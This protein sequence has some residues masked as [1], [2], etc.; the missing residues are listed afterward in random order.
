MNDQK[1]F[2]LVKAVNRANFNAVHMFALDAVFN[3]N[4]GHGY[5]R[6]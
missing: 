6:Y 3:D 4:V 5:L 1:V 2:A